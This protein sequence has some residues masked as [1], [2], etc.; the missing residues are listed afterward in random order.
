MDLS[1]PFLKLR[2]TW[3]STSYRV[4]GGTEASGEIIEAFLF[5]AESGGSQRIRGAVHK[6]KRP[7]QY[8]NCICDFPIT[9][10]TWSPQGIHLKSLK[11]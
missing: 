3:H 5:L 7:L 2:G 11:V 4:S 6:D 10:E 8:H 1:H 9:N